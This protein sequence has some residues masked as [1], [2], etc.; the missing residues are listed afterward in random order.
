MW[1]VKKFVEVGSQI[2]FG[3]LGGNKIDDFNFTRL[4]ELPVLLNFVFS[5]H[6][7]ITL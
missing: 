2:F 7:D 4:Q 5:L 3:F 6:P 1:D